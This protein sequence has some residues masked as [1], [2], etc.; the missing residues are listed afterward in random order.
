MSLHVTMYKLKNTEDFLPYPMVDN[1]IVFRAVDEEAL[2]VK[3]ENEHA[4]VFIICCYLQMDLNLSSC[5]L[6][7]S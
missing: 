2:L 6:F 5:L 7:L 3:E 1:L 4:K